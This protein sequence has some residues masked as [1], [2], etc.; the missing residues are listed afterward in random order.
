MHLT[1]FFFFFV[2]LTEGQ[3]RRISVQLF[4]LFFLCSN[5]WSNLRKEFP[6]HAS[7]EKQWKPNKSFTEILTG[8]AQENPTIQFWTTTRP[9]SQAL[10]GWS[11]QWALQRKAYNP[12]ILGGRSNDQEGYCRRLQL[13]PAGN[14]SFFDEILLA[15]RGEW[16]RAF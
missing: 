3:R 13:G 12:V 9:Q 8:E 5:G 2:F 11:L 1:L 10:S 4:T 16:A 7:Q 14:L 15:A 6:N